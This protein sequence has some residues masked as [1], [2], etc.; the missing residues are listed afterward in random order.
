MEFDRKYSTPRL[1]ESLRNVL[2]NDIPKRDMREEMILYF[3]SSM[4]Q[5]ITE[6]KELKI[7]ES[8]QSI[9]SAE[10]VL[11]GHPR[12]EEVVVEEEVEETLS[13]NQL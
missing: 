4:L 6:K 7:E 13:N 1:N 12:Y 2:E 10:R 3:Y 5:H 8:V 11:I 9:P